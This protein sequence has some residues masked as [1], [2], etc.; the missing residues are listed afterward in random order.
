[1]YCAPAPLSLLSVFLQCRDV[2]AADESDAAHAPFFP[3][4]PTARYAMDIA[5]QQGG[6]SAEI[7]PSIEHTTSSSAGPTRTTSGATA[8]AGGSHNGKAGVR[9]STGSDCTQQQPS[10]GCSNEHVADNSAHEQRTPSDNLGPMLKPQQQ[11]QPQEGL[12]QQQ[13]VV[14]Q[15][16]RKQKG[17]H[18]LLQQQ[19]RQSEAEYSCGLAPQQAEDAQLSDFMAVHAAVSSDSAAPVHRS[20]SQMR[21]EQQQVQQ[22]Q[23]RPW[24]QAGRFAGLANSSAGSSCSGSP[25]S[26]SSKGEP[27]WL[28]QQWQKL[29]SSKSSKGKQVPYSSRSSGYVPGKHGDRHSTT[30]QRPSTA[31][32]HLGAHSAA[33]AGGTGS[34]LEGGSSR[35]AVGDASSGQD[36]SSAGAKQQQLQG[37]AALKQQQ[38][39]DMVLGTTAGRLQGPGQHHDGVCN[40]PSSPQQQQQQQQDGVGQI[41]AVSAQQQEQRQRRASAFAGAMPLT[42]LLWDPCEHPHASSIAAAAAARTVGSKLASSAAHFPYR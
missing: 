22:Q 36:S 27:G 35:A 40:K 38:A 8:A 37:T 42:D 21:I 41:T 32:A 24:T 7:L 18:S 30:L 34:G 4:K 17:L 15:H 25:S 11:Q 29:A 12:Q 26:S 1:M 23:P 14:Q 20:V 39:G 9:S 6:S 31:P 13:Q 3:L 5:A 2:A 16:L 19:R 33:A 28:K 10:S